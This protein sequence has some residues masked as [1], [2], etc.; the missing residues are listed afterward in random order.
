[1]AHLAPHRSPYPG[2]PITAGAFERSLLWRGF[3]GGRTENHPPLDSAGYLQVVRKHGDTSDFKPIPGGDLP[4]IRPR[5]R[6]GFGREALR[7]ASLEPH[8]QRMETDQNRFFRVGR[9]ERGHQ[10]DAQ[11]HHAQ[12]LPDARYVAFDRQPD[13]F[14][15]GIGQYLNAGWE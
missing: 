7:A 2:N 9:G 12:I 4:P 5:A 10:A 8:S 13:R 6:L 14:T 1:D 15:T 11:G 3:P